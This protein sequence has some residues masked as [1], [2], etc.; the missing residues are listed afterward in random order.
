MKRSTNK[1]LVKNIK[2]QKNMHFEIDL[3]INL[4]PRTDITCTFTRLVTIINSLLRSYGKYLQL[5]FNIY[6]YI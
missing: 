1:M 4:F 2:I 5:G 6:I 3:N